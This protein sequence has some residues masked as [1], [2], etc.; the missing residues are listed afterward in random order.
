MRNA[1][2]THGSVVLQVSLK[3]AVG[4]EHY[5]GEA[6]EDGGREEDRLD[7]A[8]RSVH[9]I[10]TC[11]RR[12]PLVSPLRTVFA[13]KTARRPTVASCDGVSRRPAP[14]RRR[15]GSNM[16]VAAREPVFFARAAAS[17]MS[18]STMACKGSEA[19]LDSCSATTLSREGGR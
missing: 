12:D 17:R 3:E 8:A 18:A 16:A 4:R 13:S 6:E 5:T 9:V 11:A 19:T 15:S 1:L 7:L 14:A 2:R 10:N